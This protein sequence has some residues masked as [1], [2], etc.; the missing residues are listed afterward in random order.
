M[1]HLADNV[2]AELV[3]G[4]LDDIT[5]SR[6]ETH[7]DGCSACSALVAEL[8]C[9]ITPPPAGPPGYRLLGSLGETTWHAED[10]DG[11]RD[12]AVTFG[13]TCVPA[14]IAVD[15]PHVARVL[16]T[17]EL[18]GK[19]YVVHAIATTTERTWRE[20]RARSSDEVIG[21]WRRALDGLAAIHRA[22]ATC[23]LT[24]DHVFVEAD[25]RVHVAP[26]VRPPAKTSGYLAP[27]RLRGD[28]PSAR[29]DQFAAAVAL[30]E[31]L[32]GRR[33]FSGST[34]GALAVSTTTPPELPD[35]EP[36]YA[37]IAR[38]LAHEPHARWP[39]VAALRAAL[40]KPPRSNRL[41]IAAI[42]LLVAAIAAVTT[43]LL[44]G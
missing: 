31:A 20:A 19:P 12:V 14:L 32:S 26:F 29:A 39:D 30:W 25:G 41:A 9:V 21:V 3:D 23:E 8:A 43:A 10:A 5:R 6:V 36:R 1:S 35:D 27:E 42:V 24:P 16:A 28:P 2:L 13:V 11:R 37:V 15:D 18:D 17:G 7:L 34:V 22:G 40:D 38:G 4:T 44:R 33:P